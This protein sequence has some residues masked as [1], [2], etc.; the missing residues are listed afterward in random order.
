MRERQKGKKGKTVSDRKR[1]KGQNRGAERER[2]KKQSHE[3]QKKKEATNGR[4]QKFTE[5]NK[6]TGEE[7][8]NRGD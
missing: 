6:K 1:E 8:Q 5:P 7:A 2:Q 4:E 3:R